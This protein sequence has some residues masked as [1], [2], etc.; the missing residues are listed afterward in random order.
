MKVLYSYQ[1]PVGYL[2][3]SSDTPKSKKVKKIIPSGG[4]K[5]VKCRRDDGGSI[6]GIKFGSEFLFGYGSFCN[7]INQPL[8]LP[9]A[10]FAGGGGTA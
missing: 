1:I 3:A 6:T 8:F 9:S 2:F 10:P 4:K 7:R 5:G